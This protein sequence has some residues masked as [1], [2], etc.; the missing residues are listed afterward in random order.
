MRTSIYIFQTLNKVPKYP[1]VR[2]CAMQHGKS[3]HIVIIQSQVS[4]S[5]F[6]GPTLCSY[7]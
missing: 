4:K 5:L 2:T 3:G 1:L 6:V 7:Y